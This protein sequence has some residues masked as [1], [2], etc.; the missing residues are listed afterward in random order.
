MGGRSG[1]HTRELEEI[2]YNIYNFGKYELMCL[3]R[4]PDLVGFLFYSLAS[5]LT[6]QPTM[7][8]HWDGKL[9]RIW[10]SRT[11]KTESLGRTG[12]EVISRSYLGRRKDFM[13]L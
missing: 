1:H 7:N 2:N 6:F 9:E 12:L 3:L 13:K 5:F 8:F 11:S 10:Q 4:A